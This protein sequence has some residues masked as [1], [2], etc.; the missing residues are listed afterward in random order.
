M[1]SI[2]VVHLVRATN[3]IEPFARFLAS[4]ERANPAPEHELIILFK[5]FEK[6]EPGKAGLEAY[7]RLLAS[8]SYRSLSL[9][10]VG[11]DIEP[12]LTAARTFEHSYLCFLNSFSV[13]LD[14][15][16]LQKLYRHLRRDGVGLVGATASW[17][18]NRHYH[19]YIDYGSA[20]SSP[21]GRLRL[22]L[23]RGMYQHWFDPFPNYFIRTNAF[24]IA[25][26]T[27]LRGRFRRIRRKIDAYRFESGINGLT[28]QVLN[29]GLRALV[30]G[31][32]GVG[33][34]KEEWHL[35][36]TFMQGEQSN[37]LVADNQTTYYQNGDAVIRWKA[38]SASWG[39]KAAPGLPGGYDAATLSNK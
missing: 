27:L 16:W 24:M 35:S 15:D 7:Q 8:H 9:P 14:E 34:E 37:L 32:D 17:L 1:T 23:V 3:G 28:K 22:R 11:F 19:D 4:Y 30:V 21:L 29:M 26:D 36:D 12:Y 10:D 39:D 18:S 13:I 38:S 2:G 5:G 6:Q 25:R 20:Y 33:Y 31:R